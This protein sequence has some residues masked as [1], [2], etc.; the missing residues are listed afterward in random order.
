[1]S[2]MCAALLKDDIR[3]R[4]PSDFK[5]NSGT[6]P[7]NRL[8]PSTPILAIGK[9]MEKTATNSTSESEEDES[10]NVSTECEE[11][12][13]GIETDEEEEEDDGDD[14]DEGCI[15]WKSALEKLADDDDDDYMSDAEWDS[16]G[17]ADA[18]GFDDNEDRFEIAE[19]PLGQLTDDFPQENAAY[20]AKKRYVRTDKLALE[21]MIFGDLSLPPI[22]SPSNFKR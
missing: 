15:T 6:A 5:P 4:Y 9:E 1:M 11:E 3:K 17:G 10:D 7:R 14:E 16:H 2:S 22:F 21:E 20:F 19:R 8:I 13:K 12:E 18:A